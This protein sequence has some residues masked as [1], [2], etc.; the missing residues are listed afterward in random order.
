MVMFVYK[1]EEVWKLRILKLVRRKLAKIKG[2]LVS[3][4]RSFLIH[5]K[6]ISSPETPEIKYLK[7]LDRGC[8][9]LEALK[10]E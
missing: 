1:K 5:Y 3:I 4:F 6:I 2:E 8:K 9:K 10:R 7:I